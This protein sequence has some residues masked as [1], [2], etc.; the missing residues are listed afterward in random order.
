MEKRE[1]E[2]GAEGIRRG[3]QLEG[4]RD[5]ASERKEVEDMEMEN[6]GKG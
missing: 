1:G 6:R 3:V 4:E 2:G 5:A